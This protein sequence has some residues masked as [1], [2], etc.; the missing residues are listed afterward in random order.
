MCSSFR[1]KFS[2]SPHSSV[3]LTNTMGL[4]VNGVEVIAEDKS[5]QMMRKRAKAT[6]QNAAA[7]SLDKL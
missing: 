4:A 7:A 1:P 2:C 3:A 5:T 6:G